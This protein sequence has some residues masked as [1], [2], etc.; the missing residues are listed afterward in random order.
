[1]DLY[2]L[3]S[4]V[5]AYLGIKQKGQKFELAI[6]NTASKEINVVT[7]Q[8]LYV[9][10]SDQLG[11]G[12][13]IIAAA[14]DAAD[15]KPLASRLWL[16]Y[17]ISPFYAQKSAK[18]LAKFASSQFEHDGSYEA[19][20]NKENKVLTPFLCGL[21]FY[22]KIADPGQFSEL[23]K[24]ARK[25]G[26]RR[27][28]FVNATPQGGGVALMRHSLMRL[29]KELEINASW[30]VT[31]DDPAIFKITKTKFHNVLQDVAEADVK[32]DEQDKLLFDRWSKRNWE[33]LK[34]AISRADV[35]VIDDPQPSGL[36]P[37]IKKHFSQKPVVYR[38]HIHLMASLANT[39][40]T[41][42]NLTWKFI[43]NKIR[44]VDLFVAHPKPQ[45]VPA[46][47]SK[48]K[49]LYQGAT[50]DRLD[51]LNKTLTKGQ[52]D[53][54][55]EVFNQMLIAEGQKPLDSHRDFI[56]QIARFDP[57][58][59]IVDVLEAYRILRQSLPA[60]HQ[61]PQLVI[62]GNSSIDDPDGQPIYQLVRQLLETSEYKDIA[63][64]IKVLRISHMDQV[65][66]MLFQ[67]CKVA[68][69]LSHKEGFEDKVSAA[70]Y[71]SKPV[72]V[73]NAGGIPLQVTKN[74][75]GFLVEPGD[76]QK[77]AEYLK[78]LVTDKALYRKM[79]KNAAKL[80]KPHVNEIS[81]ATFWLYIANQ[82]LEGGFKPNGA[83]IGDLVFKRTP[84]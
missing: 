65:L 1:M 2:R 12:I 47:V 84:N 26:K 24:Q 71:K 58:K 34:P 31:I 30:H 23:K 52:L 63:E 72:I 53:Y 51:G 48:E 82:L 11:R 45:F 9:W 21:D 46:E 35:V 79:K 33:L 56:V 74:K 83:Y 81:G 42:Q 8:D 80:V 78:I 61:A 22:R 44:Q 38:S 55:T 32:L 62:A 36:V 5:K 15:F 57:S 25:F 28:L 68:L 39:A 17:D 76:T 18:D 27:L 19:K 29:Y 4:K 13:K 73:S 14:V 67:S 3:M 69:Q 70:L 64:D 6:L 37:F 7:T 54:Y 40:D 10:L 60:E 59:G 41:P 66:N 43:W 50:T 16:E 49:L 75:N 77:V 20:V